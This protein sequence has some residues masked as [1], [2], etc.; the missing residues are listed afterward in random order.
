MIR[1]GAY[2]SPCRRWRYA[3]WRFWAPL[4]SLH[5][6]MLN[7]S[8]ADETDNDPTVERCERRAR[9]WG[10]G[11]LIVTN[12]YAWRSTDPRAL[13][14][15]EDPVGPE[16]D[17]VLMRAVLF[18]RDTICAWGTH[19]RKRGGELVT[20]LLARQSLYALAVNQGDGTPGHPLYLPYANEPIPYRGALA[21]KRPGPPVQ[22]RATQLNLL[23]V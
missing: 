15:V 16:N 23:E 22:E 3:L 12:I 10:Y 13:L 20:G 21:W 5:F 14:K 11:G 2:F 18:A 4:P 1:R 8:T 7:P 9:E 17:A 6:M 19:G